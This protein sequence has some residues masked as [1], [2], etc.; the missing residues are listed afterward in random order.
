MATAK[1]KRNPKVFFSPA[2]KKEKK[3]GGIGPFQKENR[4][5]IEDSEAE[6]L[7]KTFEQPLIEPKEAHKVGNP[8]AFFATTSSEVK[9]LINTHD[10]R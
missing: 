10:K 8:N 7:R 4:D 2:K 6:A 1:I 3:Y 9:N 5:P